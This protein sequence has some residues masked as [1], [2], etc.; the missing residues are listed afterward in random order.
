LDPEASTSEQAVADS[1]AAQPD[2]AFVLIT[3]DLVNDG[4]DLANWNRFFA[5]DR[6]S[7]SHPRRHLLR[8]LGIRG[9]I[10]RR[11]AVPMRMADMGRSKKMRGL[12]ADMSRA[13]RR[14][15][16][17]MGP[18]TKAKIKGTAYNGKAATEGMTY[19]AFDH[20]PTAG[21]VDTEEYVGTTGVQ[22]VS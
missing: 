6:F 4:S 8:S 9:K 7:G 3:G 1:I 16:S 20:N 10:R 22:E 19:G 14:L 18:R 17:I 21:G 5:R 15:F 2:I 11:I 13:W 12:P